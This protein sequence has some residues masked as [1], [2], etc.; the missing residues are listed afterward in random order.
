MTGSSGS[1]IETL[2]DDL[3]S[4]ATG[5]DQE[6]ISALQARLHERRLRVLVVGEAKR[7]KSTLVNALLGRALLPTGATPVTAL[8]TVVRHGHANQVR[9][10]FLDGHSETRPTSDLAE[11]EAAVH[12]TPPQ[13]TA[14]TP[15]QFP[16]RGVLQRRLGH[17]GLLIPGQQRWRRYPVR[18]GRGPQVHHDRRRAAGQTLVQR[19][20]RPAT[21]WQG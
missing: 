10:N 1:D 14:D 21:R 19:P 15:S 3:R 20:R 4:L 11:H 13:V 9:V 18:L 7:G 8:H 6:Q 2:L 17:H 12:G 5:P 16:D